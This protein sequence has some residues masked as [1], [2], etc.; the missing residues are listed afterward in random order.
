MNQPSVGIRA[1]P[2]Q[3]SG[4]NNS[5]IFDNILKQY[6]LESIV[7]KM[8]RTYYTFIK[9][10]YYFFFNDIHCFSQDKI[11]HGVVVN[12]WQYM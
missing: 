3:T 1:F 10:H 7:E 9:H 4:S 5:A 2:A 11:K 6:L 12:F 8:V